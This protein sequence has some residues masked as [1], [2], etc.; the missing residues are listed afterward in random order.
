MNIK[1]KIKK[2]HYSQRGE[3]APFTEL[4]ACMVCVEAM[5]K[6]VDIGLSLSM[7]SGC[8]GPGI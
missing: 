5:A 6:G 2:N 7:R 3:D 4:L 1:S 8:R